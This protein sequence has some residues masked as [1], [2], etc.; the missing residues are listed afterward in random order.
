MSDMSSLRAFSQ[1]EQEKVSLEP[2]AE[3]GGF[4]LEVLSWIAEQARRG[5]GAEALHE[6]MVQN[7]WEVTQAQA[8]LQKSIEVFHPGFLGNPG[9][10]QAH[11]FV[12]PEPVLTSG[13]IVDLGDRQAEIVMT[14]LMPRIVVID[15]FL[16]GDE[17]EE[18]IEAARPR[19]ERSSVIQPM[20]GSGV[21][22]DART[23]TGMFFRLGEVE[24]VQRIEARIARFFHWPVQNGE[25]LQVLNYLPGTEY[26]PHQDFFDPADPG[27]PK[28]LGLAGQRVGTVLMYLNTPKVGGSTIF[29]DAGGL[30]VSAR[31]GRAV[32]FTYAQ[33][34]VH[35]RALHGG[36]PVVE[37]E[38]WAATKWLRRES[39]MPVVPKP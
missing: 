16:G 7:G 10:A 38:K 4:R 9:I 39:L 3:M 11:H 26:K 5:I 20:T 17:C 24:V 25:G 15:G 21:V 8:A 13:Q 14:C 35:Q 32:L 30:E 19:M 33:P 28:Q 6:A 18:L 2:E 31:K 34:V 12:V 23:S 36:T 37:G 22:N 27:T 29:P 1:V